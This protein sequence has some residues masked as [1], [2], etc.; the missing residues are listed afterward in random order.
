MPEEYTI[1]QM[2]DDVREG[3]L[4]RRQFMKSLT[5]MGI[6]TAG[7][8]AIAAAAVRSF[9]ST[10]THQAKLDK[11]VEA[12]KLTHLHDQHLAKQSTGDV[13]ALQHDYAVNA[14]VEDSFHPMP[15]VGR[16]AIM[17][18]KNVGFAAVSDAKITVTNRVIHGQ[19]VT[20]EWNASGVHT[21]HLP[22]L[23][24]SGNSYSING[25]TVV[26]RE[27]GKIIRESI[28]FDAADLRRQLGQ[29]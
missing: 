5:L 11:A 18:R 14:V 4:P 22:G 7:V 17:A 6:T 19:Q 1:P 3:K 28:Y 9:P 2:V 25:V 8:G 16:D 13:N 29:K 23:P 26:V 20:V 10:P 12:E 21:G 27:D 24:A 15:F